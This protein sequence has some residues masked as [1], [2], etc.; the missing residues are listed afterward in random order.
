MRFKTHDIIQ[1]LAKAIP[2]LL[3]GV[4]IFFAL[5]QEMLRSQD[6]SNSDQFGYPEDWPDPTEA[7]WEPVGGP[8]NS[9]DY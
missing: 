9:E 1:T 7:Y 5:R 3:I 2:P 6:S 4:G 8:L